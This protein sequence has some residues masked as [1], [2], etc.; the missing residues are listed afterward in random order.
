M[1]KSGW[2][3]L[4]LYPG[5][6]IRVQVKNVYHH[7][8]YVG[9]DEVVQFGLPYDMYN[10]PKDVKVLRSP[11]KDFCADDAFIEVY[12]YSRKELRRKNSDEEIVRIALSKVGEGNYNILKNNCEHFA[13]FCVFG[14]SMSKQIDDIYE[15]VEKMLNNK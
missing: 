13:N 7:G 4:E 3:M 5:A 15:N 14:D 1:K 12:C 9:N 2:Q 6:H 11:L 8:I 10:D